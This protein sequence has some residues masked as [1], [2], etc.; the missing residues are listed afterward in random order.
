MH[1][2][3]LPDQQPSPVKKVMPPA[4]NPKKTW[5]LSHGDGQ[6]SASLE[7]HK[8]TIANQL[9]ERAQSQQPSEQAKPCDREG[10]EA[11]DLGVSLRVPVSHGSHCPGNH[12]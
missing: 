3:E 11:G 6:A 8:D 2:A 9:H 7:A 4:G 5:Q 1:L 12:E 10:Y